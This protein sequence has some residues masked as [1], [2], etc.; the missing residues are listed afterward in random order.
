MP[1]IEGSK[2]FLESYMELLLVI[3]QSP[4]ADISKGKSVA[5]L[6]QG[7]NSRSERPQGGQ[8]LEVKWAPPPRNGQTEHCRILCEVTGRRDMHGAERP[9]W[10]GHFCRPT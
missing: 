2:R 8:E 6:T 1:S 5:S 9:H 10:G 7:F 4:S 3:K